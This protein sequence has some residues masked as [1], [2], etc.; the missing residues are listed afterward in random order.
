MFNKALDEGLEGLM[1][2]KDSIYPPGLRT[3]W[4]KL[5]TEKDADLALLGAYKGKGR[6]KNVYGSFLLGIYNPEDELL[7]PITKLGTGFSDA[8]LN[9]FSKKKVLE[10]KPYGISLCN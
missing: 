4:A 9:E 8:M 1:I 6:R 5:K 7:Y 3:E 2:K 10:E